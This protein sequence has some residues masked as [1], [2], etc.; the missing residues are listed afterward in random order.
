MA[1]GYHNGIVYVST[2]PGN[3]EKF[4]GAGGVGILWALEASTGKK[5]WH[6]DTAPESLWGHESVNSGG[7]LWYSP[8]FD[9]EGNM[10]V[11]TANPAPFPG[12]ESVAVGVEPARPEPVHRLDRQ[13]ERE[14]G[15]ARV[16][17]PADAA[18]P[19]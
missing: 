1:P 14:H 11:G 13:A 5:L 16:V 15:Q 8:A 4:Y 2:V 12:T 6:F 17:L 10:Y 18:R 19:V 3:N 9:N 7:G